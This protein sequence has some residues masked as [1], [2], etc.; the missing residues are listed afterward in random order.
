MDLLSSKKH[1][2]LTVI[3]TILYYFSAKLHLETIQAHGSTH[4]SYGL[5]GQDLGG[6]GG[7]GVKAVLSLDQKKDLFA[8]RSQIKASH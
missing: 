6:G 1:V 4:Y 8:H 5:T 3:N 2:S 7:E